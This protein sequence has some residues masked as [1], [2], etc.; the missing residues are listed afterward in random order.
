MRASSVRCSTCVIS[1]AIRAGDG[2]GFCSSLVKIC[3][4]CGI[5]IAGVFFSNPASLQYQE[6]QGQ[7]RERHVMV[8]THPTTH[9]VMPQSHLPFAFLEHFFY[10]VPF[11]AH[12]N[13]F[14]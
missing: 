13:H 3:R 8:P 11:A 9:F 5:V 2:G 10:A 12:T 6:P 7:E 14:P 4:T 1:S